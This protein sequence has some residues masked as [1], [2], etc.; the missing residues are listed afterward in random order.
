MKPRNRQQVE[1]VLDADFI[2]EA[3]PV[4]TL[5]RAA[6]HGR[7]TFSFANDRT[8][9]IRADAFAIDPDLQLHSGESYPADGTGVFRV[10]LDSAPDRWGRLLLDRCE[11]LRARAEK[12]PA[13]ALG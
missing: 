5:F 9:L 13:C 1:V 6:A 2:G 3:C 4:G 7:E 10:F 8:W 11:V 12:R